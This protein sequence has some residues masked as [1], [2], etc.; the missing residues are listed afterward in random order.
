MFY[1]TAVRENRCNVASFPL[2]NL[3]KVI[4][5][6][7]VNKDTISE[8]YQKFVNMKTGINFLYFC[9]CLSLN[10]KHDLNIV[11]ASKNVGIGDC[12]LFTCEKSD[13]PVCRVF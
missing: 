8:I 2:L 7:L 1:G 12:W 3:K 6:K 13:K 11:S 9:I 4:F 5:F 10:A